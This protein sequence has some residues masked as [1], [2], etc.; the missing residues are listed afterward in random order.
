M[1]GSCREDR[2]KENEYNSRLRVDL[3]A[4]DAVDKVV[5]TAYNVD[6]S[7]RKDG[8]YVHPDARALFERM[9]CVEGIPIF[10]KSCEG[11][12]PRC[13]LSLGL[14]YF[15]NKGVAHSLMDYACFAMFTSR[16]GV[17]GVRYQRLASIANMGFSI[18][19]L[20]A[21]ASDSVALFGYTKRWYCAAACVVGAVL[22]VGY[23]CL[24][25]EE[26]SAD[27]AAGFIFLTSF[28]IANVDILSEGHYSRLMRRRPESGPS[29]VS[30]I[31]WFILS[32]TIVAA[33]IQGP[34]SDKK[35]PQVGL[36]IA[37]ATQLLST[38]F[39]VLNWYGEGTNR[40]EQ[41]A[42]ALTLKRDLDRVLRGCQLAS[43]AGATRSGEQQGAEA[44]S[45]VKKPTSAEVDAYQN[46]EGA[47]IADFELDAPHGGEETAEGEV[48][49]L[50]ILSC[51]GGNIEINRDV[52]ARNWRVLVY[53]SLMTCS[54]ITMTCVT[55][56]GTRWQLL[57]ACIAVVV[58]CAT[59]AFWALPF[60]IAKVSMYFFSYAFLYL[61]LP[62]ALDSFYMA[63]EECYP[64]GPH[65]TYIFYNT[66]GAVVGNLAGIAT[67]ATFPYLFSKCSLRFTLMLTYS[68][69][70][71]ASIFDT[72]IVKRWNLH[73]GIPDHAMY[74]FG[75][76]VV[77]K[78]TY[79]LAWMPTVVLLSRICPRG[80]EST[81]YA[82]VAGFGNLG[83]S[84]SNT[85]GSL[86]MEFK[87]PITTKG[88]CDFS[89]VP[90][91]LL[92]GHVLLPMLIMPL[93][94]VLVPAARI[95]DD[96]DVSGSTVRKAES[97]HRKQV[98]EAEEPINELRQ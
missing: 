90:M 57:Y 25:R 15:L 20:A 59:C 69:R 95:C 47:L 86:L 93:S 7:L 50:N 23:G 66:V 29:L 41:L 72:I 84:M 26:S 45:D 13:T 60:L 64:E 70:V 51:C 11:Y 32:A 3:S 12:G 18:K 63:S 37:A 43:S 82:L 80:S 67:V 9:P 35:L 73:I 88:A 62:G 24:P 76:A 58:V 68:I 75:D 94:F 98:G 53:S 42:D 77:Y 96:I 39:F 38:V 31:W 61:Q 6:K 14:V 55:I 83:G 71:L 22:T 28:C 4:I 54:V 85:V 40:E 79:Y 87:W 33:A 46:A 91:L 34:L 78:V 48:P 21:M 44:D 74:L 89:N 36:F 27:I 97:L 2:E 8:R 81:V 1:A 17:S 49:E 65:F 56:L 52:C 16:F 92:V 19:A 30:W 10:G 5:Q